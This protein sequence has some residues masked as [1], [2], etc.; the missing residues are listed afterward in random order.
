MNVSIYA[1]CEYNRIV[2]ETMGRRRSEIAVEWLESTVQK[3]RSIERMLSLSC[4]T[5]IVEGIEVLA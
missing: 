3:G 4:G 2:S 1:T 5:S